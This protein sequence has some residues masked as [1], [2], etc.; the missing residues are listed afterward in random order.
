LAARYIIR[1]GRLTSGRK[2]IN[3][4]PE[5][6]HPGSTRLTGLTL[7]SRSAGGK[8]GRVLHGS[9]HPMPLCPT[10]EAAT[11]YWGPTVYY[12]S[13]PRTH[14][15]AHYKTV[16]IITRTPCTI[17]PH[18]DHCSFLSSH[19]QRVGQDSGLLPSVYNYQVAKA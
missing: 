4:R 18:S 14:T 19:S 13:G 3:P 5:K 17:S 11:S 6:V 9:D 10:S 2:Y 15:R 7:I 16:L 12:C 1:D 8:G